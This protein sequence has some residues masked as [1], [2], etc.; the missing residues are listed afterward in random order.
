MI[1]I[2]NEIQVLIQQKISI[3]I[4]RRLLGYESATQDDVIPFW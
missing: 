3:C 1:R 2:E 4:L